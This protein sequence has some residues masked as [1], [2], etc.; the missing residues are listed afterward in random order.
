MR[1]KSLVQSSALSVS[2]IAQTKAEAASAI[3]AATVTRKV[4][5]LTKPRSPGSVMKKLGI[6]LIVAPDPITAVPGVALVASS[7]VLKKNE[8]A[9]IAHLALETRKILRDV[10]S[11][12][13]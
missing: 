2:R 8:P 9:S 5:T 7:Y 3:D 6:A 13:L 11:L 12:S 1:P 4:E 10:Q